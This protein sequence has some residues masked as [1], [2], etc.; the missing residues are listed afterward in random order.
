VD[1]PCRACNGKGK[2]RK[3]RKL[4]VNIPAGVDDGTQIR[5]SGEGEPGE[6]G[7]PPGN[8]YVVLTVKPHE[9]FQRRG[10]DIILNINLNVAQAALG[11]NIEVPTV[12]GTHQIKIAAGIQTGEIITLKNK[13]IPKLR[14]DGKSHGRG[15][16]HVVVNV[17]IPTKLTSEQRKLFEQLGQSLGTELIPEQKTNF[18]E[19]MANF[20][21]GE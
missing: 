17:S 12:D 6:M 13:G 10:T 1:T 20:F 16:Q 14:P 3:T 18:F 4:M 5:L 9:I 2:Q 21:T 19:R 7:G 15:D 11:D 8:L